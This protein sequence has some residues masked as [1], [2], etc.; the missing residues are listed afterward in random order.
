MGRRIWLM[1]DG[2]IHFVYTHRTG[3]NDATRRAFYN[4]Y[5]P[6][7]YWLGPMA[8]SSTQSIATG[9]GQLADGRAL[10]AVNVLIGSDW[11]PQI[12]IDAMAGAGAVTT[13][14]LPAPPNPLDPILWPAPAVIDN[15]HIWIAGTSAAGLFL[16][17]STDY[18]CTWSDWIPV[19]PDGAHA[20][21]ATF[22]GKAALIYQTGAGFENVGYRQTTDGG[23]TWTVDTVFIPSPGD[24]VVGF[25]WNSA[26]YD[27]S[28]YL[29]IVFACIDTSQTGQGGL[30][31]SG[32]RSQIRHWNQATDQMSIVASGWW[33]LNPGPGTMHPTVSECQIAVDGEAG[34]LYCTWCQA[35]SGDV[36]ANGYSNL[37]IYGA[38]STDNGATWSAPVNIT[39]SQ[40]PGAL[41]GECEHDWWQSIT[42]TT[43]NDT[44]FLLYMNDRD[45]GS[46]VWTEGIF[47]DNPILLYP[48]RFPAGVEERGYGESTKLVLRIAPNPVS[49]RLHISY[50]LSR[51][52]TVSLKLYSIDGRVVRTIRGGH[53][54][55]GIHREILDLRGIASGIHFLILETATERESRSVI[56]VQ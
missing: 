20:S 27:N 22:T 49:D 24:S 40:S 19:D 11:R 10:I 14:A 26:A 2:G 52:S 45:A 31:F 36:A 51:N 21:W 43:R 32:C 37:E 30:S 1:P 38:Y 28:G 53:E 23:F 48:C 18:G 56:V 41:A 4:F 13:I 17:T 42:E 33:T 6:P 5:H 54:D 16:L 15:D 29:H 7:N 55:A 34:T 25:V 46:S 50:A 12:Y 39:N 44:L 9:L 8:V 3:G 47:T 35:D